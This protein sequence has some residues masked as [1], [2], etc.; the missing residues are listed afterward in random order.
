MINVGKEAVIR[1]DKEPVPGMYSDSSTCTADT[2]INHTDKDSVG[3]IIAVTRGKN[4]GPRR[5][6]LGRYFVGHIDNMYV[7]GNT[8]DDTFHYS[9]VTISRSKIG[10]DCNNGTLRRR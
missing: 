10:H 3:R 5:Y 7:G 9:H 1:T 8:G 2:W 4:P 6:V